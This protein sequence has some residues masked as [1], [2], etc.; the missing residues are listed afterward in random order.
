MEKSYFLYDEAV[1]EHFRDNDE[2]MY[3]YMM[4]RGLI[5]REV[6]TNIFESI[7]DT[8][9]S[10]LIS[11][12]AA[13]VIYLKIK[14]LLGEVTPEN[15]L[16]IS[17]DELRGCGLT[18]AKTNSIRE[19]SERVL[20]GRLKI[21]EFSKMSD[22]EIINELVQIKGIGNWTAEMI[23]IF[24]LG[25]MDVVSYKDL[26]IRRGMKKLYNLDDLDEKTFLKYR[27]NYS[28]YGTVA[29]LYLWDIS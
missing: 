24:T 7:V 2:I 13:Y 20:D 16:N 21:D 28:P 8:I 4:E 12:K 26:G 1:L 23:L 3:N 22:E 14:N 9:V 27:K 6:N 17:W 10:Q 18:T 29:S 15:V 11:T 5:E 25:R 19:I